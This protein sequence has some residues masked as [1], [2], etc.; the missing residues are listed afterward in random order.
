MLTP[1]QTQALGPVL[2]NVFKTLF[3]EARALARLKTYSFGSFLFFIG[4]GLMVK[5]DSVDGQGQGVVDFVL[6]SPNLAQII[7]ASF[8]LAF[9]IGAN[10]YSRIKRQEWERK[11]YKI[12]A[13][14]STP[15]SVRRSILK[16]L[17]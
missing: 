10:V 3:S 1:Q 11:M 15:V 12:A 16:R 8:A 6:S 14:P 9:V 2:G 4:F 7:G 13:D 5:I 17:P